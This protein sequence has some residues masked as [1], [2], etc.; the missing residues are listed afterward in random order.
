MGLRCVLLAISV[1]ATGCVGVQTPNS[2]YKAWIDYNTLAEPSVAVERVSH[3]RYRARR[4]GE[5]AWMYNRPAGSDQT[6]IRPPLNSAAIPG[7][8]ENNQRQPLDLSAP[9]SDPAESPPVNLMPPP[10]AAP[11]SAAT[12]APT[13]LGQGLFANPRHE[14]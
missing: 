14:L 8:E 2:I 13:S 11:P 4:V 3:R 6:Q 9:F 1:S 7:A 10:S 12:T 5:F